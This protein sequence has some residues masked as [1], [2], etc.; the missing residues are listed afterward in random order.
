MSIAAPDFSYVSNL[1]RQRSAIVLE[2]GKEYL[3][4][5]RLLAVARSSGASSVTDL[6]GRLRQRP[7]PALQETVVDALTTNETS[8]FRDKHPFDTF[9][10]Q[11]LPQIISEGRADRTARIWS[12]ACSSGQEPYSLAILA[13]DRLA[14]HPGWRLE[15]LA[16]DLSKASLKQARQGRYSQL[17]INRGLPASLLVKYF[18]KAGA[19]WQVKST[20][21]SSITFEELNL[22]APH[23]SLPQF[24]VIWC[25]NVLIYFDVQ[26]KR[27]VLARIR[28][29]LVPGGHLFL[30]AAETTLG[31]DET[32][33]RVRLGASTIY[34][35]PTVTVEPA[36]SRREH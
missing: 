12:A 34:R 33:Q 15:I 5:A 11:V 3:V 36:V 19:Y 14:M 23:W 22:A 24:D 20:L 9:A 31:L 32:Y 17:E 6:I 1:V 27:E 7:E 16:T 28:R 29:H 13:A 21:S 30:G 26:T 4:E 18:E 35:T 25:R 10:D 2:P 8:W